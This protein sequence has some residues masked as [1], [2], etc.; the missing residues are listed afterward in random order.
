MKTLLLNIKEWD[1]GMIN[2]EPRCVIYQV[3][4][5]KSDFMMNINGPGY[6]L[7]FNLFS[8]CLGG[9]TK[10]SMTRRLTN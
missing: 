3:M 6:C 5:Y 2:V 8:L 10:L 7:I 9:K 1:A 4:I